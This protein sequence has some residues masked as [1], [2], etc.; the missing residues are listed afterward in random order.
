MRPDNR[1]RQFQTDRVAERHRR[2]R[3]ASL[4]CGTPEQLD[5]SSHCPTLLRSFCASPDTCTQPRSCWVASAGGLPR[6][7]ELVRM[8]G[9]RAFGDYELLIPI[10]I[11]RTSHDYNFEAFWF[12]GR[13]RG[14]ENAAQAEPWRRRVASDFQHVLHVALE[15]EQPVLLRMQWMGEGRA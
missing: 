12:A 1:A 10:D 15:H 9:R 7:E 3:I 14:P 13:E 6:L 11:V 2:M 8:F 5:V 4:M